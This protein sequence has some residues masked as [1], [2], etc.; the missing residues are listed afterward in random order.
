MSAHCGLNL[1]GSSNPPSSASTVAEATGAYDHV[2]NFYIF[3]RD[4]VS[5]C[6]QGRS[7][8]SGLKQSSHLGLLCA[9][10]IGMSHSARPIIN[11][12][13]RLSYYKE[14]KV[15]ESQEEAPGELRDALSIDFTTLARWSQSPDLVIRPPW[16]PKVLR[17]QTLLQGGEDASGFN[18]IISSSSPCDLGGIALLEDETGFRHVGQG[19]LKLPTSSDPPNLTSQSIGITGVSYRAQLKTMSLNTC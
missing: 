9:G 7:Q 18:D 16:S 11:Y 6:C 12:F 8:T 3:D 14:M 15:S 13:L 17:L 2:G 5:P 10:T 19:G 1:L 4:G